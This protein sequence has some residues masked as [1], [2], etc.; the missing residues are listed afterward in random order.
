MLDFTL[1]FSVAVGDKHCEEFQGQVWRNHCIRYHR[2]YFLAIGHQCEYGNGTPARGG[3]SPRHGELRGLIYRYDNGGHG[4][5][6]EYQH[7]TLHVPMIFV[8]LYRAT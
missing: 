3:H 7:E 8:A 4:I 5:A 2:N 1:S 6:H